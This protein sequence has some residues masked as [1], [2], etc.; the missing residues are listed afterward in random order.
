MSAADLI[1]LGITSRFLMSCPQSVADAN[2]PAEGLSNS[3]HPLSTLNNVALTPKA[4]V[5]S[6][7]NSCVQ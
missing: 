5:V 2:E 6:F 4:K 3:E 7:S 1:Y